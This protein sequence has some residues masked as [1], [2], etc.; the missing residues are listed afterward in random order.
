MVFDASEAF[1]RR[2]DWFALHI[3]LNR[4]ELIG[5]TVAFRFVSLIRLAAAVMRRPFPDVVWQHYFSPM[6]LA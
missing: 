6:D 2:Q 4:F 3:F 1:V 5:E